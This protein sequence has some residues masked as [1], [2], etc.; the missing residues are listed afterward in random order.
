MADSK[1]QVIFCNDSPKR[2][3]VSVIKTTPIKPKAAD[4]LMPTSPG[5]SDFMVYPWRW[6]ENAH[7]VT[8]SPGSG[9]GTASPT[10]NSGSPA[11]S[12]EHLKVR[13]KLN[14][15]T[16]LVMIS[17]LN[18]RCSFFNSL[19]IKDEKRITVILNNTGLLMCVSKLCFNPRVSGCSSRFT[20]ANRHC[21]KHPYARL[22]REEPAGGSG[23]SQGA[24][25]K[26][27]AEWL[28]KYWQMREQRTPAPT[29]AKT[30]SKT[31]IEDQE[32]QDPLD[33]LPSDEGEE[34]EQDE[35]K[36]GGG[37]ARRRLQEQRERLHGALALIEL[38]NN[39]S[40]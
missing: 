33:F 28:A 24:D 34:E 14:R 35:E 31:T 36:S 27:V 11:E 3:L 8:L 38:A 37:T 1:H 21:P 17:I 18:K 16:V 10:R 15:Y 22:K 25:N 4:S 20:H 39:L 7:N 9:S 23:K 5:F 32:Q 40:A 26:A 30:L 6:G 19:F 13:V 2:V 29:K 12:D